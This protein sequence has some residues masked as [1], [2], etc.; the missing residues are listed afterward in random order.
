MPHLRC[1]GGRLLASNTIPRALAPFFG[2]ENVRHGALQPGQD[3]LQ[4]LDRDALFPVLQPKKGRTGEPHLPAKGG[5]GLITP[6]LAEEQGDLTV[7]TL[8]H[9]SRLPAAIFRMRNDLV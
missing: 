8:A 5:V 3:Q 2:R 4:L 9:A 6:L 7:E 1:I